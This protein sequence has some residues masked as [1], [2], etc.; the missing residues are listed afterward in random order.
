[1]LLKVR[2]QIGPVYRLP[3]QQKTLK[4]VNESN[5]GKILKN[6]NQ[7]EWLQC[8]SIDPFKKKLKIIQHNTLYKV[9]MDLFKKG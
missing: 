9:R 5:V 2:L 4:S 8:V 3:V 6:K 1:M 7:K